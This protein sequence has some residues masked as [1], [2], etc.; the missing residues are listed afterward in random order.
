MFKILYPELETLLTVPGATIL[1]HFTAWTFRQIKFIFHDESEKH[2]LAVRLPV[3]RSKDK[4]IAPTILAHRARDYRTQIGLPAKIA[5]NVLVRLKNGESK[6]RG[7]L[8]ECWDDHANNNRQIIQE[9]KLSDDQMPQILHHILGEAA[10]RFY[11]NVAASYATSFK[12]AF[13]RL[14]TQWNPLGIK[15]LFCIYLKP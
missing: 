15:S 1:L 10:I 2:E 6:F 14:A 4:S 8:A 5:H 3:D 13:D 9:Y 7:E 11:N 12:Q